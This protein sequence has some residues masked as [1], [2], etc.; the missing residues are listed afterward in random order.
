MKNIILV[1][2]LILISM[3]INAGERPTI[4]KFFEGQRINAV[5]ISPDG[6]YLALVVAGGGVHYVAVADRQQKTPPKPVMQL[7]PKDHT[8]FRWCTWAKADRV[9]CSVLFATNKM[10]YSSN[11]IYRP[12]KYF[13]STR[14]VAFDADG[15]NNK[16]LVADKTSYGGQIQDRVIDW[17]RDDPDNVLIELPDD[18]S[19]IAGPGHGATAIF[20]LNVRNGKLDIYERSKQYVG[21][22]ATDGKGHVRLAAGVEDTTLRMFARPKGSDNWKEIVKREVVVKDES[23][24]LDPQA[25]IPDTDEAYAIGN[26]NGYKALWSVSL[27]GASEPQMLFAQPDADVY[28]IFGPDHQLLGVG[29]DTDKPGVKYFDSNAQGLQDA[30]DKLFPGRINQ[31]IDFSRDMNIAVVRSQND[32][33]PA[34]FYVLD[35]S[36]KPAKLERA[37]SGFPALKGFDMAKVLPIS[38]PAG[39]GTMIPGYLTQPSGITDTSK[40]PMIVLPHGGPYARD[41]W[42]F[43]SWV[44]YLASRGYAVLQIEFRGSTGYGSDWFKSG[45][46]DWGGKP[47]SDVVDGTKWALAKGYGDPARTC[48]V[49]ASFGG[50]MALL[51]ATRNHESK[52]Y[53]CAVSISG[54]SDLRQLERD[55]GWF[56]GKKLNQQAIGTDSDKLRQDSPRVHVNEV[57]IP[58][59]LIHGDEDYTVEVG[60]SKLM[61]EALTKADKPHE[62]VIIKDTDHYFRDDVSL[63]A[64]FT[65]MDGFL[66]KQLGAN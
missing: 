37:G 46:A 8:S 7:D 13:A 29:F 28:S 49:G 5:S 9:V 50:Y 32:Q 6:H 60:E 27:T 43:D 40:A 16:V 15:A 36:V 21:G 45:F 53:K 2:G 20:K 17:L 51:A 48:I 23:Q 44:Q 41:R 10:P 11:L 39:D 12:D 62:L 14:I 3:S 19:G 65:A 4:D 42:G 31:L 33:D 30:A 24:Y 1:V 55:I 58:I 61:D 35:L 18:N 47:Y 57:N 38:F 54:V 34:S 66:N 26:Y 25:V 63:R 64:M 59:M 22:F 56:A 52:L